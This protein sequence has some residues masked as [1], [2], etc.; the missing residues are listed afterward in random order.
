MED[1]DSLVLT[2][3]SG[4]TTLLRLRERLLQGD[5]FRTRLSGLEQTL[6]GHLSFLAEYRADLDLTIDDQRLLNL[7]LLAVKPG[8]ITDPQSQVA[9][10]IAAGIH[11][12]LEPLCAAVDI[13]GFDHWQP[14]LTRLVADDQLL[15][16]ARWQLLARYTPRL[17]YP[18]EQWPAQWADWLP[19]QLSV[20]LRRQQ[21]PLETAL[22]WV[23]EDLETPAWQ[24]DLLWLA[25]S[26]IKVH[27]PQ[28]T[29]LLSSWLAKAP[30][31]V[32]LI[33]AIVASGLA[34]FSQTLQQSF[35]DGNIP[36]IC[37]AVHGDPGCVDFCLELLQDP[38]H[39][40][41]GAELWYWLTGQ[42]LLQV[43]RL[44]EVGGEKGKG[45]MANPDQAQQWLRQNSA[46]QSLWLGQPL[47]T[48]LMKT[49]VS[50]HLGQQANMMQLKLWL[51]S[52]NDFLI[53]SHENHWQRRDT[54]TEVQL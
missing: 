47:T 17:Q 45:T 54:I 48:G 33:N 38:R 46:R 50:C 24:H 4:V 40:Q 39:N 7:C 13:I 23:A 36:A 20:A 44:L 8:F 6:Q 37:L 25:L 35:K 12:W 15:P 41:R 18:V 27:H 2:H 26:L 49:W 42:H 5:C 16:A 31:S 14:V 52:S 51:R 9:T 3:E 34:E 21:L 10:L 29:M 43:P 30:D 1:F 28:S 19:G 53:L 22:T 11:D 32:E